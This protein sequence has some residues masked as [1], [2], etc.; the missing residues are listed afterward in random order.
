MTSSRAKIERALY[1][2]SAMEVTLG[3]LLSIVL[4]IVLGMIFLIV[5]PVEV[6][7]DVPAQPE[8][9]TVYYVE[10]STSSARGR[11][12]LRK[13]QLFLEGSAET[14]ALSEEEL[15]TWIASSRAN[16][17]SQSA[18]GGMFEPKSANFRVRDSVFQIALPSS[19]T[20]FGF[21][22]P[23]VIQARGDFERRGERFVFAPDEM[24]LGSLAT[25]RVPGLTSIV[26]NR[27]LDGHEIP[28]ETQAAWARL[29]GVAVE[30][31]QLVLRV[32]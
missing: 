20:L 32:R 8:A 7:R 27:L 25:H 18:L 23:V 5:K 12:Y 10:G 3:A 26:V 4:G 31:D 30:G 22:R 11:Q 24:Y 9:R 29:T 21:D 28:P 16:P 19:L 2:P 15:N 14:I 17:D 6:V 13:R 1:G